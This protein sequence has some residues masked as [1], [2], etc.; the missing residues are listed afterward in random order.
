MSEGSRGRY[1]RIIETIFFSNYKE[2]DAEVPF[3]RDEIVRAAQKLKVELPKN[4]GD[5]VYSLRYRTPV[6]ETIKAK[7]PPG[8]EWIIEGVGRSQYRFR[9][10]TLAVIEPSPSLSD[11]KVPDATPGIIDMYALSDEQALLAKLRY[12]R[13]IDVFLG[14][15]C[16]SLQNHLR[17]TV[18]GLGQVE[19]DEVY[20]GLDKR[21]AQYVVPVQA[22]GG[23]DK[24]STVQIGQ[25]FA[26]CG[27]KFPDLICV[28]AAAQFIGDDLS[29]L[30]AFEQRNDQP[31]ILGERHYRLVSSEDLDE[32]E[33]AA[34]R[35]RPLD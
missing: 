27:D 20:I 18:P 24:T 19:T 17:T 10:T 26:M 35:V 2:G 29:A 21:G 5:V 22:K 30:F 31:S 15:T 1:A 23:S 14:L 11:T 33:L 8:L 16:Y 7:A 3:E 9:A 4:L 13:L 25:D 32:D 28:P 6:P 34:Y 12:N